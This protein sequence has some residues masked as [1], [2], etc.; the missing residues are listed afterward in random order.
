MGTTVTT[1]GGSNLIM[2]TRRLL[3][4][5][6]PLSLALE[7]NISMTKVSLT[8]PPTS[9]QIR[10]VCLAVSI[11][12]DIPTGNTTKQLQQR[13][14]TSPC[15]ERDEDGAF[16]VSKVQIMRI[17]PGNVYGVVKTLFA[18]FL[19]KC[20][21]S[22]HGSKKECARR[23]ALCWWFHEERQIKQHFFRVLVIMS[24]YA[25]PNDDGTRTYPDSAILL[26]YDAG[27]FDRETFIQGRRDTCFNFLRNRTLDQMCVESLR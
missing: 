15:W 11:Q 27:L 24:Q 23:S 12:V 17:H 1:G 2:Y 19:I 20:L 8:S 5:L 7:S 13:A 6:S 25:E 26:E 18:K 9:R 22:F 3:D 10:M 21:A 4:E 16:H 14:G